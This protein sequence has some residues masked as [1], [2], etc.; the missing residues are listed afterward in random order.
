MPPRERER[1]RSRRRRGPRGGD[2]NRPSQQSRRERGLPTEDRGRGADRDQH[3]DRGVEYRRVA[4]GRG[5]A[6]DASRDSRDW[7]RHREV[8]RARSPSQPRHPPPHVTETWKTR[9]APPRPPSETEEES[10]YVERGRDERSRSRARGEWRQLWV[11]VPESP[12]PE[13]ESADDDIPEEEVEL[14]GEFVDTVTGEPRE[15]L[16]E[17]VEPAPEGASAVDFSATEDSIARQAT[18]EATEHSVSAEPETLRERARELRSKA[19]RPSTSK[20]L[21]SVSEEQFEEKPPVEERVKP[22]PTA[23]SAKAKVR[24]ESSETGDIV[25]EQS[26]VGAL[27]RAIGRDTPSR[28]R[29]GEGS[30]GSGLKRALEELPVPPPV[31]TKEEVEQTEAARKREIESLP[32][33]PPAPRTPPV[34][35]TRAASKPRLTEEVRPVVL[36]P[37]PKERPAQPEQTAPSPSSRPPEPRGAPPNWQ[38]KP[39]VLL[40]FHKT[41][42]FP[43][44][45]PP[46]AEATV[47]TLRTVKEKGFSIGILSFASNKATQEGVA[48]GVAE[49]ERRLG[50]SFDIFAITRTKFSTDTEQG[51]SITGHVG[52]KAKLVAQFGPIVYVDDQGSLLNDVRTLQQNVPIGHKTH[53]IRAALYPSEALVPLERTLRTFPRTS[54]LPTARELGR[55]FGTR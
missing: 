50:W 38:D 4:R 30:S 5:R 7:P 26:A 18:E 51:A 40:D 48:A 41:L 53:C 23:T 35:L 3:R 27:K 43:N 33:P 15:C 11:W 49:L 1:E 10:E 20:P 19:P 54:E 37:R 2:P 12:E 52:S 32:T 31:P 44:N 47:Q 29:E 21:P 6:R 46:V 14:E 25:R 42:S 24:K 28:H 13:E 8:Y 16:A 36:A 39:L 45:D 22:P 55:I 17:A 34:P 9:R